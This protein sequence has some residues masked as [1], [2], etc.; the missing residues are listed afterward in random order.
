MGLAN[1]VQSIYIGSVPPQLPGLNKAQ[2]RISGRNDFTVLLM[3]V[4]GR[5]NYINEKCPH[6]TIYVFL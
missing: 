5:Q 4:V 6:F 3:H 2:Y 1:L